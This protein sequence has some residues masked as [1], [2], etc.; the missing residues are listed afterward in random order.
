MSKVYRIWD[1][2]HTEVLPIIKTN[3]DK[4]V[5]ILFNKIYMG[6]KHI[7]DRVL[8]RSSSIDISLRN[9]NYLF[10][11]VVEKHICEILYLVQVSKY[12]VRI[13]SVYKRDK[14]DGILLG[15]SVE[16][17]IDS[18]NRDC[19]IWKLVTYIPEWSIRSKNN[20]VT[21]FVNNH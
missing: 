16:R 3:L 14:E 9:I 12:P 8:D 6:D 4:T 1:R 17:K 2:I 10:N 13:N 20:F 5:P 15:I 7:A 19:L 18:L 11:N 21:F